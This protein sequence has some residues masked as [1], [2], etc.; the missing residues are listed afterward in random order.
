M[1][2]HN[3]FLLPMS[4]SQFSISDYS[5]SADISLQSHWLL[6]T[7]MLFTVLL[8]IAI[9]HTAHRLV[10]VTARG[11]PAPQVTS[12]LCD[13]PVR[14]VMV[15]QGCRIQRIG[16]PTPMKVVSAYPDCP[17]TRTVTHTAI[18]SDNKPFYKNIEGTVTVTAK[19]R[20][21]PG[22]YASPTGPM[23]M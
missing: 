14:D 8:C 21:C 1:S 22:F 23:A 7:T 2:I 13:C 16:P 10:A 6:H 19:T 3:C 17:T 9:F 11:S 12:G 5:S 20:L 4:S 15:Y 18:C